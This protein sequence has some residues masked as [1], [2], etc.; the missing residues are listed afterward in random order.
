MFHG[1]LTRTSPVTRAVLARLCLE[2]CLVKNWHLTEQC[3]HPY[4]AHCFFF[5]ARLSVYTCV[6]AGTARLI[7][8]PRPTHLVVLG[9]AKRSRHGCRACNVYIVRIW[10]SVPKNSVTDTKILAVPLPKRH[11][12]NGFTVSQQLR[13]VMRIQCSRHKTEARRL[14]QFLST[15]ALHRNK[16]KFTIWKHSLRKGV[17]FR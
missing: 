12:V 7:G 17:H 3:L 2:P 15:Q 4:C 8:V 6:K 14:K 9:T 10:H 5:T 1:K 11:S 13:P 16:A